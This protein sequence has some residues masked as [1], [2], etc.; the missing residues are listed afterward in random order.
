MASAVVLI[1][2][3]WRGRTTELLGNKPDFK[4]QKLKTS[5][6]VAKQQAGD[7]HFDFPDTMTSLT[8]RRYLV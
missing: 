6:V 1:I 7:F 3:K 2:S 4:I 5:P 8:E